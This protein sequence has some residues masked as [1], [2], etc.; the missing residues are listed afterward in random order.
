VRA[1]SL[2]RG[3]DSLLV[4]N[5]MSHV[6]TTGDAE[7]LYRERAGWALRQ[8]RGNTLI[9][10]LLESLGDPDWRVQAYAA[11]TLGVARERRA[12]PALLRALAHPVWRMR[13]M[14]AAALVQIGDPNALSAMTKALEDE[15][16]QVRAPAVSFVATHSVPVT[17]RRLLEPRLSDR[18]VA[19]RSAAADA[20][21]ASA[22][23]P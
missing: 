6:G 20:L 11:W 22:R 8:A 19:V 9:E 10:P 12:V 1:S 18:H 14:A 23:I 16:W 5:L 13:A 3:P 4:R 17:A 7:E 21:G 15:A 2:W